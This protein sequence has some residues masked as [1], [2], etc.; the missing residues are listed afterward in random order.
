ML[1]LIGREKELFAEDVNKHSL[2]GTKTLL[3]NTGLSNEFIRL[4][5]DGGELIKIHI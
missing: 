3:G 4:L 1:Q 5:L 2:A